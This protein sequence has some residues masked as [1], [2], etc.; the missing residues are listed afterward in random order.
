MRFKTPLG[1]ACGVAGFTMGALI[2]VVVEFSVYFASGYKIMD[3]ESTFVILFAGIIILM[4]VITY[5]IYYYRKRYQY[6][7]SIKYKPFTFTDT[8]G[9]LI[10]IL[11]FAISFVL[12]FVSSIYIGDYI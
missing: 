2:I 4:N 7:K 11:V 10:T 5:Y 6:I 12:I 1:R 9:L 3:H 8:S